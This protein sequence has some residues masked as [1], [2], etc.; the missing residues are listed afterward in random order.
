MNTACVP[1]K[2]RPL[3]HGEEQY[4]RRSCSFGV[5]HLQ[6]IIDSRSMFL[7]RVYRI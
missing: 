5:R 2:N 3:S 1:S 6:G 4:L 7:T